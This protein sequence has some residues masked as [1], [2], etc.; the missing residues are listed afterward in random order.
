MHAICSICG[1][2]N[3]VNARFCDEC[4]KPLAEATSAASE[5]GVELR[6]ATIL[7][8]DLVE[9][10]RLANRLDL[11]DLRV[12]FRVFRDVVARVVA[13]HGGHVKGF[14]GDGAFVSFG[15]PLGRE[16]AE[17]AAIRAAIQLVHALE[18][19]NPIGV[20]LEVRVGIASGTVVVGDSIAGVAVAEESVIGSV[21]HLAARLLAL[22]PAG[23][24]VVADATR[25]LAGRFFDY[26]DLG[27][28]TLKG[29]DEGVQAWLVTGETS[30]AS[31]FEARRGTASTTR[32]VGRTDLMAA[33]SAAWEKARA[34]GGATIVLTGD[35][36]IGKSR[37]ARTLIETARETPSWQFEL[38]CTPRT[39]LMPLFPISGL[40]L[41]LAN[42]RHSDSSDTRL[43]RLKNLLDRVLG[44][45]PAVLASRY[46]AP[47]VGIDSTDP[48]TGESPERIR[49][50]TI[51]TLVDITHAV[52]SQRP[53]LLLFEDLHWSDPTTVLFV[54]TLSERLPTLPVLVV[55]TMRASPEL[56][57]HQ[58]SGA[59]V[60]SLDPLDAV[61]SAAV[62]RDMRGGDTLPDDVVARIVERAE[63]NPLYLEE[64]TQAVVD[65]RGG[66]ASAQRAAGDSR[67]R[68]PASLQ[69]VI[70]ARLD[71]RPT[72]RPVIQAASV[73]GREFSLRLLRELLPD[74]GADAAEAV[75]RFVDIGLLTLPSATNGDRIRFK[76]ALI[77]ESVYQ[78]MLR[79]DRQRLHSRA[80]ELLVQHFDGLPDSAPDVLAHHLAGARRFDEAVRAFTAAAR[81]TAGR[82]AYLEATGH[83][84]SGLALIDEVGDLRVRGTLKLELLT[85][86]GVALAATSGYA[87][88]E[89]E[90]TYRQARELCDPATAHIVLFPI[91]RGLGTFYFVRCRLDTAAEL[92]A[93]CLKLARDAGRVDYEI[94]ALSF[95]GYTLLYQGQ[96]VEGAAALNDCVALYKSAGGHTLRYPSPQ[97][98]GT[99][100]LSLLGI[101]CWLLGDAGGA[102]RAVADT[103]EHVE[104]LQRP[105]DTAYAHVWIAMLRNMQRR[106]DEAQQHAARCIEISHRHGFSTWFVAAT[107]HACIAQAARTA[108]PESVAALRQTLALFHQ[109]GAEA[110]MPFFL[111]GVAQGLRLLG[112]DVAARQA[113]DEAIERAETTGESYLKS[114]LLVLASDLESDDAR[115]DRLLLDAYALAERQHAVPLALR[116]AL[117]ILRRTVRSTE[118]QAGD[119]RTWDMLNGTIV[120][121]IEPDWPVRA[122]ER[123]R[124]AL[125]AAGVAIDAASLSSS[126]Y[127]ATAGPLTS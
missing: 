4:G 104:R 102:E 123:A 90:E 62:V 68:I 65:Q 99:A 112:D 106:F 39:S 20:H 118:D 126:T 77:H 109:A 115:A 80:A 48:P 64:L 50:C 75:A 38:N 122:L 92:S 86:L 16:D 32:L 21:P 63:G 40:L 28:Q 67:V 19:S 91:V 105:F 84:R 12:V 101:A 66:A 60:V 78:T 81:D 2:T 26:S 107:M 124:D 110:N 23:G 56:P 89:V 42:I 111:W 61:S 74:R 52:A 54:Q 35:P 76:H 69:T 116:A 127:N 41:Q 44:V 70:E 58:F 73:L 85:Q 93:T 27:R 17:E 121:A 37:L 119:G 55:V 94:E 47:L 53:A 6:H 11:E 34:G 5:R 125:R 29:F 24:I 10:T 30:I 82:A 96:L 46:L 98:A 7:F 51:R 25:R 33:L 120:D 87:A 88:P 97:D 3:R 22:A 15:Y 114:E 49:E 1:T 45:D 57:A 43:H 108:A 79:A 71:R 9:S 95:R 18:T 59:T 117:S 36:G 72:L 31:R 8:C 14:V 113:L 100:A 13:D 103:L 83:C